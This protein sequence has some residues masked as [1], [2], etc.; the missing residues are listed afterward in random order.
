VHIYTHDSVAWAVSGGTAVHRRESTTIGDNCYIGPHTVVARGVHIGEGCIIGAHSLVL[1]NIPAHSKAY[2]SPCRVA[3]QVT[4][5]EL[6]AARE[7][8]R[9]YRAAQQAFAVK[10]D[11]VDNLLNANVSRRQSTTDE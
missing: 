4:P 5:D 11:V 2:G 7:Q 9:V 10:L 1:D 6:G 8:G 3:G